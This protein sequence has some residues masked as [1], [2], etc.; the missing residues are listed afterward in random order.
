MEANID[1]SNDVIEPPPERRQTVPY[2]ANLSAGLER[3]FGLI[4]ISESSANMVDLSSDPQLGVTIVRLSVSQENGNHPELRR[5]IVR[6]E[7][8][9]LDEGAEAFWHAYPPGICVA[10]IRQERRSPVRGR[11]VIASMTTIPARS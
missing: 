11:P 9:G 4:Q 3:L 7:G 10:A 8:T 6:R 2:V 1:P 5:F